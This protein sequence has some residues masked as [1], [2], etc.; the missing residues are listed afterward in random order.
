MGPQRSTRLNVTISRAAPPPRVSTTG[1]TAV[2]RSM[3]PSPRPEPCH[4]RL[5]APR[6]L[7]KPCYSKPNANSMRCQA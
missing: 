6:P 2:A 3:V 4:P 1:T 5:M 7:P